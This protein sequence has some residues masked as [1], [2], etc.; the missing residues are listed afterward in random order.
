MRINARLDS[1]HSEKLEQ[2]RKHYNLSVSDVV[3]QAIDVMYAQQSNELKTKL[4]A[5]LASEFID[6]GNGPADL[7]SNYKSYLAQ[8]L[9]DKHG[10]HR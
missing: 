6:C 1:E 9:K 7:S 10:S 3:K 4:K 2:L 8:S 5:L